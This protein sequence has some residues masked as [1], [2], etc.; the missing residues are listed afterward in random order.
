[1]LV[2]KRSQVSD[3]RRSLAGSTSRSVLESCRIPVTIVAK[4]EKGL[5]NS[6]S[7]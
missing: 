6:A 4:G 3:V 7:W 5:A 1:V 2:G